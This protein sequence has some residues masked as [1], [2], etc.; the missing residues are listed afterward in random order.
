M[1]LYHDSRNLDFRAPGGALPCGAMARIRLHVDGAPTRVFLRLWNGEE[2]L[3][4]MQSA[5]FGL[6]EARVY[7]PDAPTLWWYD[8]RAEDG[9]GGAVFYGNAPDRMGGVGAEYGWE[10]PSYQITVYDPAF[11]TPRFLRNGVMYQIFPDR[12][13][14]SKPPKTDR[15]DVT[16]HKDWTET[17]LV[18]PDSRSGDNRALDF[19]G[20]DLTG[21]RQKL[22]YLRDLGVTALYL[23]PIFKAR[24]NHRY[25]T[26]DYIRVDELLGDEAALSALCGDIKV[27]LDGVF[28]HTGEDSAYFNRYGNYDSVGACQSRDSEYYPWYSFLRY[29]DEYKCWW[30]VP[31]LPEVNKNAPGYRAFILGENGVARHWLKAGAAGWRL[32]VADELPID[33]LRALRAA[34]KRENPG[35]AIIGEVWEDASNKVAYGELRSYCLGDTADS[36]MNYPLRDALIAF[37]TGKADAFALA[38][39]ICCQQENYPKPFFYSLMNLTGSHDRARILNVLCGREHK[40]LPWQARGNA[41]LSPAERALAE[42]RFVK[43][44]AILCALPGIPCLYYGDENGM[45]GAADPFCRAPMD[46]KRAGCELH[47]RARALL[48]A[49]KNRPVMQTGDLEVLAEDA[50]TLRIR[51]FTHAGHDAFGE[52][53]PDDE[54]TLRVRR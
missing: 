50:D 46:W 23:N 6:Y 40:E 12:F 24:S 35:A 31:S 17:P 3:V 44:L 15:R 48:L 1:R 9:R 26:G 18:D 34:V 8:F 20:G 10:P 13:F 52:E 28:S 4:P 45:E 14:A 36:V 54:F 53:M 39:L 37:L 5:G 51:R 30:G 41:R 19:F 21:I 42:E 32:D 47:D 25:D 16:L 7:A 43:M 49:R 29:P 27:V 11:D 38:R 33:F 2:Q 22:E